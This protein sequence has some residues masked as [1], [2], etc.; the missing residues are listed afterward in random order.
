[1]LG[2]SISCI[3]I[4]VLLQLFVCIIVRTDRSVQ[5]RQND[6]QPGNV[7]RHFLQAYLHSLR[8]HSVQPYSTMNEI[9]VPTQEH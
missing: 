7:T 4:I 6:L 2:N 5:Y 1:M 3:L 9:F 8:P